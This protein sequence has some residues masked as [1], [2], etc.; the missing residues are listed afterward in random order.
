LNLALNGRLSKKLGVYRRT[1]ADNGAGMDRDELYR[2]F[3]TLGQG[4]KKI[5]GIHDNFGVGQRSLHFPG[6][7]KALWSSPIKTVTAP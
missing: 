2:F 5:G 4:A 6:T 3:S 7:R 1:V